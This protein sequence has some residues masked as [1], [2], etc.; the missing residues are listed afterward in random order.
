MA[1]SRNKAFISSVAER[2]KEVREQ[3][4]FTQEI[5][6]YDTG[7]NIGRIESGRRDISLTTI[8]ALCDYYEISVQDFFK[9]GF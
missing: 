4:G 6:V 8:K 5:V 3:K 7:I 1:K 2:L 9:K